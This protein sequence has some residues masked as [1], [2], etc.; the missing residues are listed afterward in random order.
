MIERLPYR[1]APGDEWTSCWDTTCRSCKRWTDC[2]VLDAMVD[3]NIHD[4]PWPEKGWVRDPGAGMTC[5][6]YVP[7]AT[8]PQLSRQQLRRLRRMNPATLPQ[9]CG[10]CAASK[11]TDAS[12]S[13]H[14]RRDFEAAVRERRLFLCHERPGYCAGWVR[15][16]L[17]RRKAGAAQ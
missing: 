5:L 7:R 15:A 6:S 10:G 13:L 4:T 3:A 16:V 2:D 1:P 9:L 14:T 12:K 17:A 8:Q 11:G